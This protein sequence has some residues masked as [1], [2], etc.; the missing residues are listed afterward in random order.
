MFL[1]RNLFLVAL[2]MSCLSSNAELVIVADSET[3]VQIAEVTSLSWTGNFSTGSLVVNYKN[4]EKISVS[5][6]EITKVTLTPD[7][8]EDSTNGEEDPTW[9]QS[10]AADNVVRA[11]VSGDYLLL[12]GVTA[13]DVVTVF[14]TAGKCVAKV[15]AANC[16]SLHGLP[17]GTY[18][19]H[20]GGHSVKFIK[21]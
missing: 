13:K 12:S 9:I 15:G 18:V 17:A 2:A 8:K 16:I 1:R 3:S 21:R 14:N 10:T 4:G 5:F 6:S 19:A 20:V 11:S 7:V